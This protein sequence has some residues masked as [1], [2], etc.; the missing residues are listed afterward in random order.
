M[1]GQF[2]ACRRS[3]GVFRPRVV[4][5][6]AGRYVVEGERRECGGT[7]RLQVPMICPRATEK[8]LGSGRV[9][10][11]SWGPGSFIDAK[12]GEGGSPG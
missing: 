10:S 1:R 7:V 2:E 8:P 6:I 9:A 4:D 5:T 11:H 12:P 3:A